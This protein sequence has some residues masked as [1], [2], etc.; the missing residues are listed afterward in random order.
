MV[1]SRWE[2]VKDDGN[3]RSALKTSVS[4]LPPFSKRWTMIENQR[5]MDEGR[6]TEGGYFDDDFD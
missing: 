6:G 5:S 4:I 1:S 3:T 2:K